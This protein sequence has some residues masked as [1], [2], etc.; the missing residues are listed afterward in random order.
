MHDSKDV[1]PRSGRPSLLTPESAPGAASPSATRTSAA[2]ASAS[3]RDGILRQ[4]EGGARP[5]QGA[6]RR[7]ASGLAVGTLALLLGG[8]GA[9]FWIA[10][11]GAVSDTQDKT[12]VVRAPAGVAG[13]APADPVA[14]D[15]APDVAASAALIQ[16]DPLAGMQ[17]PAAQAAGSREKTLAEALDA[18]PPSAAGGGELA[19]LL[20]AAPAAAR[21][22]GAAKAKLARADN[23][24]AQPAK[25][26]KPA[27][28]KKPNAVDSDVALLAALLAHSKSPDGGQHSAEF[29]RCAA[30]ASV[31]QAQR[32]RARLCEG[33]ARGS[34]ECK[35]VRVSKASG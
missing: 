12:V 34:A 3:D 17:Q 30:L 11:G 18:P 9:I 14:V 7:R 5:A 19:A 22:E 27:P 13:P 4:L 33:D 24:K 1:R 29:A 6:P 16:D 10:A 32:C 31:T 8:V 26:K 21:Q 25:A 20:A 35:T 15:A 28:A 23:K 2:R